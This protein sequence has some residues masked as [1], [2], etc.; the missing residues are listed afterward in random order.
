VV[1][2]AVKQKVLPE[3]LHSEAAPK[4]AQ[5]HSTEVHSLIGVALVLGFVFMLLVDQI[6]GSIHAS[7]SSGGMCCAS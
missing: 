1:D 2:D 7:R 4:P 5:D 6:G 3:H